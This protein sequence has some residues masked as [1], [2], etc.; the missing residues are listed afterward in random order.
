VPVLVRLGSDALIFL[1]GAPCEGPF[2]S[3]LKPMREAHWATEFRRC[4]PPAQNTWNAKRVLS[5]SFAISPCIGNTAGAERQWTTWSGSVFAVAR[6][7]LDL[8]RYDDSTVSLSAIGQGDRA[9]VP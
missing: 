8:L 5:I 2:F 3:K 9:E 7:S 1:Q 4:K 6:S